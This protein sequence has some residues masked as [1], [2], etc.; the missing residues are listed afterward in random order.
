M[1]GLRDLMDKPEICRKEFAKLPKR[2]NCC[3]ASVDSRGLSRATSKHCTMNSTKNLAGAIREETEC[4]LGEFG[5][6]IPGRL[7]SFNS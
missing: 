6:E 4:D 2:G 3:T 1:F 5:S 7:C